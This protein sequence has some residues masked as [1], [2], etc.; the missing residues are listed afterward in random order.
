MH[1]KSGLRI[2][3]LTKLEIQARVILSCGCA[4]PGFSVRSSDT[5]HINWS[6]PRLL[7]A[8][9][10]EAILQRLIIIKYTRHVNS[11]THLRRSRHL[12]ETRRN[13]THIAPSWLPGYIGKGVEETRSKK[14]IPRFL[15]SPYI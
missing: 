10:G 1:A 3:H 7:E 4:M 13:K 9:G 5:Q 12:E 11:P 6:H 2:G 14:H 8:A 15:A